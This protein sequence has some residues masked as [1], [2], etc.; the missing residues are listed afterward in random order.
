MVPVMQTD[1]VVDSQALRD[2]RVKV[3]A[4]GRDNLPGHHN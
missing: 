4:A 3:T 1:P 2:A